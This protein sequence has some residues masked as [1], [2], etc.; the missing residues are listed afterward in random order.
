MASG[1]TRAQRTRANA[2]CPSTVFLNSSSGVL[3]AEGKRPRQLNIQEHAAAEKVDSHPILGLSDDL[4]ATVR[5]CAQ[6]VGKTVT[7]TTHAVDDAIQP[8]I[9]ELDGALGTDEDILWFVSL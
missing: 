8:E 9:G 7:V 4:W 3:L 1:E 6:D 5:G 2:T